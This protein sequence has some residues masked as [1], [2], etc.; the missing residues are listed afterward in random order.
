MVKK[1]TTTLFKSEGDLSLSA[2]GSQLQKPLLDGLGSRVDLSL[3]R[4]TISKPDKDVMF[5]VSPVDANCCSVG[6]SRTDSHK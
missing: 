3:I 4:I 6:K 1:G 5:L 2:S